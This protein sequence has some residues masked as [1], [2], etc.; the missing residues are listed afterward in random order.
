MASLKR[1]LHL[2][3]RLELIALIAIFVLVFIVR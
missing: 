2:F 1:W 3:F